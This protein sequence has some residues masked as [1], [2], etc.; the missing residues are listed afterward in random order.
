[1]IINV[2]KEENGNRKTKIYGP[3]RRRGREVRYEWKG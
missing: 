1:M 2:D 3:F